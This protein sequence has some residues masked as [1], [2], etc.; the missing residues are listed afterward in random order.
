[1]IDDERKKRYKEYHNK[2]QNE[3]YKKDPGYRALKKKIALEWRVKNADKFR[4]YQRTYQ[5]R[6]REALLK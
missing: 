5:K 2:W 3:K 6:R 4:E 1:M